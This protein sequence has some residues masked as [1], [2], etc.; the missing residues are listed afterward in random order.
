MHIEA[1]R[2]KLRSGG[3]CTANSERRKIWIG[4]VGGETVEQLQG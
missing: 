3:D 4:N 2:Q 1:A